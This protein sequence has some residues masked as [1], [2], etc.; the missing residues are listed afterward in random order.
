M[1]WVITDYT[2]ILRW[3]G[4][5]MGAATLLMLGAVACWFDVSRA[6]GGVLLALSVL[7]V[8]GTVAGVGFQVVAADAR[9]EEFDRKHLAP[10][11]DRMQR[12]ERQ[13]NTPIERLRASLRSAKAA[14]RMPPDTG[15][16]RNW[17]P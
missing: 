16:V 1:G 10:E 7:T 15:S 13:Q 6:L 4:W 5:G 11:R 9:A 14:G 8:G 2:G 17:L 3:V 12:W